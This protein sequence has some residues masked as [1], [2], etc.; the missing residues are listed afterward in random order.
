LHLRTPSAPRSEHGEQKAA[1]HYL[2]I[3]AVGGAALHDL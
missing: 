2:S 1:C 3:G